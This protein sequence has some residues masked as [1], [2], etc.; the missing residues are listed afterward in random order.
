MSKL[1]GVA[2]LSGEARA[3]EAHSKDKASNIRFGTESDHS[4]ISASGYSFVLSMQLLLPNEL[5]ILS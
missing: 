2:E 3:G 5:S 1:V 4:M